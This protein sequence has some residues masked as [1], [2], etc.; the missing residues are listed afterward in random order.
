MQPFL[1]LRLVC[2]GF[3][4]LSY[5]IW[6]KHAL[7]QSWGQAAIDPHIRV[8]ARYAGYSLGGIIEWNHIDGRYRNFLTLQEYNCDD[9][10]SLAYDTGTPTGCSKNMPV[11]VF[12]ALMRQKQYESELDAY[13]SIEQ[14]RTPS[15]RSI[16]P[17]LIHHDQFPTEYRETVYYFILEYLGPTLQDILAVSYYKRFS[18]KMTMAVAIQLIRRHQAIHSIR[19]IHN[20]AKT[21]N[22]CLPPHPSASGGKSEDCSQYVS[23]IDFGFSRSYIPPPEGRDEPQHNSGNGIFRPSAIDHGRSLSPREDLEGL[24]YTLA[25]L[26]KGCLPWYPGPFGYTSFGPYSAYSHRKK[27]AVSTQTIFGGMDPIYSWFFDYIIAMPWGHLPD[28]EMILQKFSARWF[29]KG[30]GPNPGEFSWYIRPHHPDYFQPESWNHGPNFAL[31]TEAFLRRW[32]SKDWEIFVPGPTQ[33]E[34]EYEPPLPSPSMYRLPPPTLDELIF[35][36][37]E[38][39]PLPLPDAEELMYFRQ[40]LSPFQIP[41]PPVTREEWF[42]FTYEPYEPYQESMIAYDQHGRA[43]T[44]DGQHL[45]S[46][47]TH[48]NTG[49][50]NAFSDTLPIPRTHELDYFSSEVDATD[51]ALPPPHTDEIDWFKGLVDG[52]DV[53]LPAASEAD[54]SDRT[55]GDFDM[56]HEDFQSFDFGKPCPTSTGN[57]SGVL[58]AWEVALPRPNFAEYVWFFIENVVAG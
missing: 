57:I 13:L 50:G 41:L 7:G 23:V 9:G 51:V 38:L 12:K 29:A 42:F 56:D 47:V 3:N 14:L 5:M 1:Q 2:R 55:P 34:Y 26:A 53:P 31:R 49:E 8:Q 24:A 10:C 46:N 17:M 25:Y 44:V 43:P 11:V 45:T 37:P 22:Y 54:S 20:G 16:A 15:D 19:L 36:Q 32:K 58:P 39:Q 40:G 35:F 48:Q 30:F 4:I 28:Y 33:D 27:R 6:P 52:V 18:A 21:A